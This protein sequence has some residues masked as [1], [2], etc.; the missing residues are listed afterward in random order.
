M[1]NNL[2]KLCRKGK[3][4]ST[5]I[6]LLL[7]KMENIHH[8]E[9]HRVYRKDFLLEF[10]QSG[11]LVHFFRMRVLPYGNPAHEISQ[12]PKPSELMLFPAPT[13]IPFSVAELWDHLMTDNWPL[14]WGIVESSKL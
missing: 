7:E 12:T 9:Y 2:I 5:T 11:V 4:F 8:E 13:F 3:S 1:S 6:S 14:V 10:A